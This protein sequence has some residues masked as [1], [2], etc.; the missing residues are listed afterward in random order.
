[1]RVTKQ[2]KRQKILGTTGKNRKKPEKREIFCCKQQN[3]RQ[4]VYIITSNDNDNIA[5]D[6]QGMGTA[7]NCVA[8]QAGQSAIIARMAPSP[9]ASFL[10]AV[11]SASSRV[12]FKGRRK[13]HKGN[14]EQKVKSVVYSLS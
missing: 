12:C 5:C 11:V 10:Y 2:K 4:N 1:M 3:T 6:A 13:V 7:A 14:S 8:E 9:H